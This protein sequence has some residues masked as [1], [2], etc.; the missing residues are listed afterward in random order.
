MALARSLRL[1]ILLEAV[2]DAL[3]AR[4]PADGED[5]ARLRHLRSS[6]LRELAE[7]EAARPSRESDPS[8]ASTTVE[9]NARMRR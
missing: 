1:Q 9:R 4:A 5:A 3:A 6:L 2:E 8:A 7:V